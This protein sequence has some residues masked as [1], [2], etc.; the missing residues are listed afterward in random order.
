MTTLD[1]WIGGIL[2]VGGIGL[3]LSSFV[4]SCQSSIEREAKR[5]SRELMGLCR[6]K[7]YIDCP[8]GV[9]DFRRLLGEGK[10]TSD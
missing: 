1:E 7:G 2:V 8:P 5:E 6:E 3:F 4:L 9:R 10:L